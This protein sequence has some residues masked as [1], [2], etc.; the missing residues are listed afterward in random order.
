MASPLDRFNRINDICL[1]VDDFWASVKFFT[2]VFGFKL[3]RLQPTPET[4]N[5]A[6]FHFQDAT[7]SLWERSAVEEQAIPAEVLGTK[8]HHFMIAVKVPTVEDVTAIHDELAARGA[9]V[10]R[11][12]VDYPF[13]S[14]ACY[15][16]DIEGN[17]WEVFAWFEGNG[18]GVLAEDSSSD[19]SLA[20]EEG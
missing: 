9:T 4:A 3:K 5:Y 20:S 1:F 2:D 7:L 12:P 14:R 10:V 15:L 11:A 6:E 19:Q 13:G 16:L 18:P 8:G 17:V